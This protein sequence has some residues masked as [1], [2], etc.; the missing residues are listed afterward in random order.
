MDELALSII[1]I[2]G[3]ILFYN[4]PSQESLIIDIVNSTIGSLMLIFIFNAII[5]VTL[6]FITLV[7]LSK[8]VTNPY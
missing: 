7:F 8:S 6:V 4:F 5:P 3:I 2:F 1:I